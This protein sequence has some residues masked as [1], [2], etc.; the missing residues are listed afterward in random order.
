MLSVDVAESLG[1]HPIMLY[2]WRQEMR[3]GILKDNNQ[4]AR[5]I[6]KLLSAERKIK[7]LEAE[8]KKVRE[9][10]TVLKKAEL[11]FPGK[12]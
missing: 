12:K 11:F 8:L 7:K 10:N 2:R 9:E 1:I 4:E 5:S 3:E 6:S